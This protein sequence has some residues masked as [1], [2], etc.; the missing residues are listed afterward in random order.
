MADSDPRLQ[1]SLASELRLADQPDKRDLIEH[2][3]PSWGRRLRA[4]LSAEASGEGGSPKD[5]GG[6]KS[7]DWLPLRLHPPILPAS[8]PE[9]HRPD[10]EPEAAPGRTQLR[11]GSPH[12]KVCTLAHSIRNSVP[13]QATCA[14]F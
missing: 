2:K 3:Q 4:D 11:K 9:L 10:G 7:D 12:V 6:L 8:E 13:K 14:G 1:P 5:E